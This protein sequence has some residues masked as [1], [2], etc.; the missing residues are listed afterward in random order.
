MA[1]SEN[2]IEEAFI[3]VT[4]GMPVTTAAK[5]Y[6]IP[7]T[8]LRD[9]LAGSVSRLERNSAT[10]LLSEY[11]ET[12]LAHW[13]EV[14]QALGTSPSHRRVALAAV[15]FLQAAHDDR[16]PV[17]RWSVRFLARHPHLRTLR[18]RAHDSTRAQ[19]SGTSRPGGVKGGAPNSK[20]EEVTIAGLLEGGGHRTG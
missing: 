7:R 1:P 3:A 11:Q 5:K 18:G 2:L 19:V 17:R 13:I 12:L 9:R 4:N 6:G 16:K 14:Q 15:A 20:D 8:T 10:M